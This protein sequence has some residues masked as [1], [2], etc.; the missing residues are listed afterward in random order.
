L[1][2]GIYDNPDPLNFNFNL[3]LKKTDYEILL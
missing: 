3:P 1:Q 2:K